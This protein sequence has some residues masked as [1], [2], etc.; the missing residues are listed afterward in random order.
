MAVQAL[1]VDGAL[2]GRA[3]SVVQVHVLVTTEARRGLQADFPMGL[4]AALAGLIGVHHD[5]S[6]VPLGVVV[7]VQTFVPLTEEDVRWRDTQLETCHSESSWIE[8]L[9]ALRQLALEDVAARAITAGSPLAVVQADVGMTRVAGVAARQLEAA[10]AGC[11]AVFAMN[12]SLEVSDVA[13]AR[14]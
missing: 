3:A 12:A 9:G 11:V 2:I 4:M 10:L 8:V 7:A 6:V 1:L 5:G 13:R 14:A